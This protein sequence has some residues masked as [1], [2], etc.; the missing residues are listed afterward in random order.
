[1][2]ED[3]SLAALATVLLPRR[4]RGL[5]DATGAR[6]Q[7]PPHGLYVFSATGFVTPPGVAAV[8]TA[9]VERV[10]FNSDG[11]VT[12]PAVIESRPA[13]SLSP[14]APGTYTVAGL[15]Q[16]DRACSATLTFNDATGNTFNVIIALECVS[17][18]RWCFSPTQI[19]VT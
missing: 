11:T 9:I 8:P 17:A 5:P 18:T 13:L 6:C 3:R 1:M 10:S 12:T 7:Q 19:S 4:P 15:V 16:P 14:G 2:Q